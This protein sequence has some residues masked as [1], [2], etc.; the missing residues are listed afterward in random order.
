MR[1]PAVA[2]I[3]VVLDQDQAPA[4]FKVA[5]QQ[6]QQRGFV[7]LEVQGIGHHDSIQG[8]QVQLASEIRG[9]V[10]HQHLWKAGAHPLCLP[11]QHAGIPID[12]INLPLAVPPCRW[13]GL[14]LEVDETFHR[15][16]RLFIAGLES[17]AFQS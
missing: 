9:Q 2:A 14:P 3:G 17:G 1:H 8:R 16:V 10:M 13:F 6:G 15:L 4:G 5:A 11:V 7:P 12:R